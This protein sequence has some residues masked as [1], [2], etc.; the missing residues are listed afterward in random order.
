[1][2]NLMPALFSFLCMGFFALI[3]LGLGIM[4]VVLNRKNQKKADVSYS[5][6]STPGR[7]VSAE[8]KQ[9]L[10]VEDEFGQ[11]KPIYYPEVRYEYEVNGRTFPGKRLSFGG[12]E[13]FANGNDASN[14]IAG[15]EPGAV[16]KVYYDPNDPGKSV[17][18]RV[19]KK[20]SLVI[21]MGVFFIGL[22]LCAL[23]SVLVMAVLRI[24]PTQ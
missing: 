7:L 22:G 18:D 1:M 11:S 17:L 4:L 23:A 12:S 21:V 14:R 13:T 6:P 20:S 10:S 16:L 2:D 3:F 9:S 24:L 5:W 8:V 19:A 15:F